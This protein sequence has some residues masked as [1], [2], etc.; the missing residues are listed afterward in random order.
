MQAL[1]RLFFKALFRHLEEA[2]GEDGVEC[3]VLS[4]ARRR[5][6]RHCW[7]EHL[8]KKN[9]CCYSGSKKVGAAIK[10]VG[11]HARCWREHLGKKDESC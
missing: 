7:R 2:K 6:P 4:I 8:K 1:L 5:I 9:E 11:S 10:A 3:R